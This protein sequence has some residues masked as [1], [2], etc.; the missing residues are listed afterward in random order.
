MKNKHGNIKCE[1]CGSYDIRQTVHFDGMDCYS[2]AGE[3]S[4]F[5]CEV[6]LYCENCGRVYP[7]CR[8]KEF[9][10]ISPL[11]IDDFGGVTK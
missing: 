4:G 6:T 10:D 1:G 8:V 5:K 11:K 2:E 3:G 9:H 7:I